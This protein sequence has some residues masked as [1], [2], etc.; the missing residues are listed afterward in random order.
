MLTI[1]DV[2]AAETID[3]HGLLDSRLKKELQPTNIEANKPITLFSDKSHSVTVSPWT[4]A[5]S[6]SKLSMS[7]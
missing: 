4:S 6:K 7:T 1:K 5:P 2:V 3:M